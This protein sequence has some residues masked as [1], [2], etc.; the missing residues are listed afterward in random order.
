MNYSVSLFLTF[1]NRSFEGYLHMSAL[2]SIETLIQS[3]EKQYCYT[4]EYRLADITDE[5]W[6]YGCS[7]SEDLLLFYRE[8]DLLVECLTYVSVM[9]N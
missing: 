8:D 3:V 2:W 4:K 6:T 9:V 5:N 7:N 1:T